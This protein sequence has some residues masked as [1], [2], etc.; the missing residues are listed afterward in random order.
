MKSKFCGEYNFSN[1]LEAFMGAETLLVTVFIYILL[2][3]GTITKVTGSTYQRTNVLPLHS[4]ICFQNQ[5][6]HKMFS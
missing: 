2:M 5:R 1:V 4:K 3:D 6:T